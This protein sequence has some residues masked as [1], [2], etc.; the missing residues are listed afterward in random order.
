MHDDARCAKTKLDH[1]DVMHVGQ[2][3]FATPDPGRISPII[4][5]IAAIPVSSREHENSGT[6]KLKYN[7]CYKTYI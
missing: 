2:F 7:I 6:K 1:D 3:P 5:I 4:E